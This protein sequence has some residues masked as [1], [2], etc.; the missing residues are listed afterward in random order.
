LQGVLCKRKP[1]P[2]QEDLLKELNEFEQDLWE[3]KAQ[4]Y[5]TRN[6]DSAVRPLVVALLDAIITIR[7][8]ENELESLRKQVA[9]SPED[10]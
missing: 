2:R 4:E 3:T 9:R 7:A 5:L 8:Q 6:P 1:P 10:L